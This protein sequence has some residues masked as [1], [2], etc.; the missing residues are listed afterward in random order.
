MAVDFVFGIER[1]LDGWQHLSLELPWGRMGDHFTTWALAYCKLETLSRAWDI[2]KGTL[3][4][5]QPD[6]GDPA[7]DQPLRI[8]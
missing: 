7:K 8:S 2:N 5:E 4:E 3:R 1:K 6:W